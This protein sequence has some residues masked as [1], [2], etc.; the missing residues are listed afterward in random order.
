[1]LYTREIE[2]PQIGDIV[3]IHDESPRLLWNL[4]R[5]VELHE[6]KDGHVRSVKLKT[7]GGTVSRPVT[8]LYPLEVRAREPVENSPE[9]PGLELT[10]PA[11]R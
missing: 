8:L 2:T 4:G 10:P 5:V 1:M 3:Q 11:P 6:S 9:V 7:R